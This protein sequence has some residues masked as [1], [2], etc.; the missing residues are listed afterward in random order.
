MANINELTELGYKIA[1]L[2]T[3]VVSKFVSGKISE[4]EFN[5]MYQNLG[6]IFFK[7]CVESYDIN[8][9]K[10]ASILDVMNEVENSIKSK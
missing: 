7:T 3:R 1:E 2:Q 10:Y 6:V 4:E 5:V 8:S 9:K